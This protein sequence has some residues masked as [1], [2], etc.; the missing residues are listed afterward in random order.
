MNGGWWSVM[1]LQSINVYSSYLGFL[2]PIMKYDTDRMN[3]WGCDIMNEGSMRLACSLGF[4]IRGTHP[5][6]KIESQI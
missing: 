4:E 3:I 1:R 5:W 6:Y 2:Y